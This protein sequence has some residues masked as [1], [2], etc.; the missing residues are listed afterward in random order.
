[1]EAGRVEGGGNVA[2]LEAAVSAGCDRDEVEPTVRLGNVH[3]L[4]VVLRQ[5]DEPAPLPPGHGGAG[6]VAPALLP[7]LHLDE[8]PYLA[9]A[10]HQVD[11]AVTEPHVSRHDAKPRPLEQAG[12]PPAPAAARPRP[13]RAAP[14]PP[15]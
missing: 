2:N 11:L 3:P 7:A 1:Q 6:P 15:P 8:Y 14:P 13:R 5:P 12:A 4:E 10:A 9:V